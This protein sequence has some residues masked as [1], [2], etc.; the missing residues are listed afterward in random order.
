MLNDYY[1]FTFWLTVAYL[2]KRRIVFLEMLVAIKDTI[3]EELPVIWIFYH[4]YQVEFLT[5]FEQDQNIL[6]IT[7]KI[8]LNGIF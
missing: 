8:L 7:K 2:I 3:Y 4:I 1:G 6:S 5:D